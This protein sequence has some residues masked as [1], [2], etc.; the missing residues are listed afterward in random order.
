MESNG[1]KKR[2][3]CACRSVKGRLSFIPFRRGVQSSLERLVFLNII[4]KERQKELMIFPFNSVFT[5]TIV[6]HIGLISLDVPNV[7]L[8][9]VVISISIHFS[10]AIPKKRRVEVIIVEFIKNI[11]Q[12][13]EIN[14]RKREKE[15]EERKKAKEEREKNQMK[16]SGKGSRRKQNC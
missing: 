11:N 15:R 4:Q 9:S 7:T 10:L 5:A 12:E 6:Q 3:K 8:F 13:R 16:R 2:I 1:E 14:K